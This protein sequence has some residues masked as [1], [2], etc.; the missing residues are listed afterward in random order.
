MRAATARVGSGNSGGRPGGR[1]VR[2]VRRRWAGNRGC[3]GA[4]VR[5]RSA[6]GSDR[7]PRRRLFAGRPGGRDVREAAG[8]SSGQLAVRAQD[9]REAKASGG[10]LHMAL[11]I[12]RDSF[13]HP[14]GR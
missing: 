5:A 13:Q 10:S 1:D 8:T 2:N 3:V 7:D 11:N 4:G 9:S 6:G 12:C 14:P